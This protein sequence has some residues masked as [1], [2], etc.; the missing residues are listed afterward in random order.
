[1]STVSIIVPI[2]NEAN[3]LPHLFTHI[4]GLNPSPV[5][6]LKPMPYR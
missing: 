1:M 2:L 5:F 6:P 4:A 3:N